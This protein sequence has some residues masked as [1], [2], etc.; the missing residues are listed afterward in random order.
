MIRALIVDDEPLARQLLSD[1]L[2]DVEFVSIVGECQ[3]GFQAMKAIQTY[4]PDLIFLDVQMPRISGFELLEVL[5]NPPSIIFTT[6]YDQYAIRAFELNAIDYLLKPF[7]KERF[8]MAINK[9]R[10][11]LRLTAPAENLQKLISEG[12]EK[13]TLNRI[14]VK[15]GTDIRIIPLN[16]IRYLEAWDDY[17][18]V[19]T[20]NDLYLKKQT[21]HFYE[22]ALDTERFVRIHRS[23][24]LNL[25]ELTRI[26]LLAK[27]QHQAIL[28]DGN[29]LPLSRTGYARLREALGI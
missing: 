19:H 17:V 23:F 12:T 15:S 20:V 25:T 21:L 5:E 1:Y 4:K 3:D 16:E 18:K 22:N 11:R 28:K 13:G 26:E 14:V 7:S 24:I 6:A 9:Y 10:E 27:D 8:L 29:T 2:S